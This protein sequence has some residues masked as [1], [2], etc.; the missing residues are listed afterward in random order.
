MSKLWKTT[1]R[2]LP[3]LLLTAAGSLGLQA[4]AQGQIPPMHEKGAVQYSCGGIGKDESTAMR[5]AM[6]DYPLSLLF[7]A[8]DGEYL[9]DVSVDIQSSQ[10]SA[11]FVA[12]GPVCLIKLPAGS[13]KVTATSKD[14]QS[15]S[16][17]V[18][19]GKSA[20]SLDFRF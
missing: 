19:T 3:A 16:Q 17:S 11:Q 13:Y 20:H 9:A 7:A 4:Q 12:G 1:A 18:T 14:G 2:I 6:K 10:A 8:K 15:H 5:A